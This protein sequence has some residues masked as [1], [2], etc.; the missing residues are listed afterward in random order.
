MTNKHKHTPGPWSLDVGGDYITITALDGSKILDDVPWPVY[1]EE[2]MA[3]ARLIEASPDLLEACEASHNAKTQAEL[4]RAV[5]LIEDAIR[6]AR[7][8][9]AGEKDY[10]LG[11]TAGNTSYTVTG[12]MLADLMTTFIEGGSTDWLLGAWCD[13]EARTRLAADN[14]GTTPWYANPEFFK[15]GWQMHVSEDEDDTGEDGTVHVLNAEKLVTG[16]R[17]LADQLP[18]TF[19]RIIEDDGQYDVND[20]DSLIQFSLFGQLVYG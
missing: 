13:P 18:T 17:L 3:D 6:K 19:Q 12:T 7:G 14:G 20:V 11:F 15:I 2:C 8:E 16:F 9:D 1:D 5:Q 10:L 4:D